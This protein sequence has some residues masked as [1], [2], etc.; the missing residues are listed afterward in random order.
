MRL[1]ASTLRRLGLAALTMLLVVSSFAA[2]APSA[3]AE[4][5]TVKLGSDKGMLAFEPA[6]LS[7]QPGD[8]IKW[9]NNKV[10]PHN[11]VFDTAQNP[12]KSADLAKTLSHKQLVM[13]PGQEFTTTIPADAP[14]GEYTFYCEPHRGAGMVGKVIV[15][16]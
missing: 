4:T 1:I 12:A 6:K 7:V 5:Y 10:P 16:G 8:T 15:E 11:V 13:S 14:A 2:F 9:V 3:A